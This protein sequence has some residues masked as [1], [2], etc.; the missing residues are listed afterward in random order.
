MLTRYPSGAQVL[1]ASLRDGGTVKKLAVVV[2]ADQAHRL[3]PQ[4]IR[5]LEVPSRLRGFNLTWSAGIV[6]LCHS[7]ADARV[8]KLLQFSSLATT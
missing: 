7:N 8:Y 1:A 2:P 6:R 5:Q 4:T 3:L